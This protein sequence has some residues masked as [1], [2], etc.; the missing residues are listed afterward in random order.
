MKFDLVALIQKRDKA[1][2]SS[3]VFDDLTD[4]VKLADE[5]NFE[6]VWFSPSITSAI[7]ACVR[8]RKNWKIM[9]S[10]GCS[11]VLVNPQLGGKPRERAMRT[12]ELM[13]S[14]IIPEVQKVLAGQGAEDPLVG[15]QP[16]IATE[17]VA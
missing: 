9:R 14:D 10:C 1:G 3:D 16:T 5:S 11:H 15:R 17:K 13:A 8:L 6:T 7:T 12:L 4:Q 2:S